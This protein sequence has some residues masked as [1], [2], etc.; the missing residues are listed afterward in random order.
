MITF[1]QFLV[2]GGKA[3]EKLGTQR[4]TKAD[5]LVAL[6][7]VSKHTGVSVETLK[8]RLLGSTRLT[9]N[10]HQKDSGDIDLALNAGDTNQDEI[11]DRMTFATG[12]TKPHVTGGNIF[13]FAVP[14]SD[15]KKVQVDLMFVP[16]VEWAKFSHHASEHS[17]HKSGVRNE[18]LH[19]ALKFSMEPGKDLRVKD[20]DGNDI[21]RA[22]R[23][24]KLDQGVERIFKVSPLRK[25]GKGA[26]V[27]APVKVSPDQVQA[28][29]DQEGHAGKFSHEADPIRDPDKFAKLLF[30]PKA[31]AK[32]LMSTEQLINMIKKHKAKD[33]AA[34]FADAVKGIKRL[35][36]EVP[37]ELKEY[38]TM[39]A[40]KPAKEAE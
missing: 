16:D 12:G 17:K 22:S 28:A 2:E 8:D 32:D 14:V 39:S 31:A 26:R 24:Y 18:L 6:K 4:A 1:K 20:E 29:L 34:I 27:K 7:F 3:T 33:A 21:A 10:D 37:A 30:G 11:V 38:D 5:M 35:K 25:D 23:A 13:S 36:F 15:D 40:P 19:S 9:M